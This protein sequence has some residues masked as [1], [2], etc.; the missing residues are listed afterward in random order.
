ML[1]TAFVNAKPVSA[2]AIIKDVVVKI[3]LCNIKR[4]VRLTTTTWLNNEPPTTTRIREITVQDL[5][6]ILQVYHD[7]KW[8]PIEQMG[9]FRNGCYD[10][11][12]TTQGF[13]ILNV[14]PTVNIN[15]VCT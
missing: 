13:K 3:E 14:L 10:I 8:Y 1:S 7:H 5:E 9:G 15:D 11:M 6:P 2:P 12:G 4:T